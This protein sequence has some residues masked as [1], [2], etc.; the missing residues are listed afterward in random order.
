MSDPQFVAECLRI[1]VLMMVFALGIPGF[2]L[3]NTIP[4]D[5]KRILHR[6]TQILLKLAWKGAGLMIYSACTAIAYLLLLFIFPKNIPQLILQVTFVNS[7][8]IVIGVVY[9]WVEFLRKS[10]VRILIIK[11]LS[12]FISKELSPEYKGSEFSRTKKSLGVKKKI[13][14]HRNKL[15][16]TL[17]TLG[18]ESRPGNEKS[19]CLDVLTKLT[20][21]ITQLDHKIIN[22]ESMQQITNNVINSVESILVKGPYVGSNDNFTKGKNILE[23]LQQNLKNKDGVSTTGIERAVREK[24]NFL[25]HIAIELKSPTIAFRIVESIGAHRK[26][27]FNIGKAA[28]EIKDDLSATFALV[29]LEDAIDAKLKG[30][31]LTKELCSE[32]TGVFLLGL[33]AHFWSQGPGSAAREHANSFLGQ[34]KTYFGTKANRKTCIKAAIKFFKLDYPDFET[35]DKLTLMLDTLE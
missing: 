11:E 10:D 33:I 15:F 16:E 14:S 3:Q 4:D 35:A 23:S 1:I 25:T 19:L 26:S 8:L 22:S 20:G 21:Q 18:E 6:H 9:V 28:L 5:L 29:K 32:E 7:A 13:A 27:L 2:F 34:I 24:L 12:N 17:S 31:K 30:Q